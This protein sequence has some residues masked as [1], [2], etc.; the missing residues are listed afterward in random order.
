MAPD[1][2][3]QYLAAA[4]N[5]LDF[6][7]NDARASAASV[8]RAEPRLGV[9]MPQALRD[10]YLALGN[11][12][13]LNQ[14]HNHLLAPADWYLESGELVFLVENQAVVFWGVAATDTRGADAAVFQ[15]VNSATAPVEWL[16][17]C[18]SCSEFLLVMLHWQVAMVGLEFCGAA[19]ADGPALAAHL[20]ASWER[21]GTV[22][23]MTACRR[24]GC[25]ACL[26]ADG[27]QCYVAART[28][29][30]FDAMAAELKTVGAQVEQF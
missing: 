2:A 26:E 14:A 23:T 17:E 12:S 19:Q 1:F 11:L 20:Q 10:Y 3:A 24:E 29:E 4:R 30:L 9:R 27:G 6:D 25:A 8:V 28:E 15:G 13:E 22:G 5:L 7:P 16:P 18:D 21:V